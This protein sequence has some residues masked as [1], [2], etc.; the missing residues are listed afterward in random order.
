MTPQNWIDWC[1]KQLA[2]L[3]LRL[4]RQGY[5]PARIEF[6]SQTSPE[7]R[8]QF[9]HHLQVLDEAMDAMAAHSDGFHHFEVFSRAKMGL[10]LY[11][12]LHRE[13]FLDLDLAR[14]A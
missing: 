11:T 4:L 10:L 14:T 3:S 12:N 6:L 7:F 8:E 9:A 13:L 1:Q 5:S 2:D